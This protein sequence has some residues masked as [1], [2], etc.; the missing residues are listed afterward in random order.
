MN[1]TFLPEDIEK[2]TNLILRILGGSTDPVGAGQIANLLHDYGVSLS[3]R[4]VRYH[5]QFMDQRGLTELVG[6]RDG[7]LITK[8]GLEELA[9]ARVR[10]K[11]GLVI[12]KI[13]VLAFKTTLNPDTQQGNLPVNISLFPKDQLET[14][15]ESMKPAFE[16]GLCVSNLIALASEGERLGDTLVPE[17]RIGIATVC[18]IV[19]NGFLLK[20]G[21]PMDSKFAG[22]LEMR[23]G[24]PLRFAELIHYS[25]S[26]LDPSE[27]FIRGKMTAV[28]KV[29][30]G[31]G[32]LLANF[33]E[34]PAPS[35]GLVKTLLANIQQA[36]IRG[37]LTI[38]GIGET[39]CQTPVDSN[40]A[41]MVLAGGLNPVAYIQEMGI[42]AEN[43]AMSTIM[44]YQRLT[45]FAEICAGLKR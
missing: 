38:G 26:S 19:I 37:V 34:I 11:V 41:G 28:R 16:A 14:V 33:R 30:E 44:D 35:L 45:P 9:H 18:S 8:L 22:I 27:V 31:T 42:E 12:S 10:D 23:Q 21:I 1:T 4:S 15:L 32:N 7:R 6:R 39:V 43:H 25:G 24:I 5:L 2:K 17:G 36:G 29:A 40:K 3:E 13:E 20:N